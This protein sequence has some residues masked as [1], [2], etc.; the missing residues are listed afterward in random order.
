[1]VVNAPWCADDF[2]CWHLRH[3]DGILRS[4]LA[5]C[6]ARRLVFA[7]PPDFAICSALPGGSPLSPSKLGAP[8]DDSGPSASREAWEKFLR[9]HVLTPD[10]RFAGRFSSL[11]SSQALLEVGDGGV[12]ALSGPWPLQC[13]VRDFVIIGSELPRM[14]DGNKLSLPQVLLLSMPLARLGDLE[15]AIPPNLLTPFGELGHTVQDAVDFLT[16]LDSD[17]VEC[18]SGC[19][20]QFRQSH[21]GL[22]SAA[23]LSSG[24]TGGEGGVR[25]AGAAA[26][27]GSA[28]NDGSSRGGVEALVKSVKELVDHCVELASA[29]V[30]KRRTISRRRLQFSVALAVETLAHSLIYQR[31]FPTMCSAGQDDTNRLHLNVQRLRRRGVTREA[32][33]ADAV[34]EAVDLR[35]ARLV[36]EKL[37]VSTSPLEVLS[38]ILAFMDCVVSCI[39]LS[40]RGSLSADSLVPLLQHTIASSSMA[41]DTDCLLLGYLEYLTHFPTR[42]Q[43]R[44]DSEVEYKLVSF[45]V[46]VESLVM[47][48]GGCG[49][50]PSPPSVKA[51]TSQS[52]SRTP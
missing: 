2:A 3:A 34:L 7:L 15:T 37:R 22:R 45:R 33:G 16:H 30:A 5:D 52:G 21:R 32:L 14:D 35:P 4:I 44:L 10:R 27:A 12:A 24:G 28:G 17:V 13:G 42:L 41:L 8:R 49:G 23:F 48:G 43:Q 39:P 29:S 31:V 25:V 50:A 9:W 20:S 11:M 51:G 47:D 26:V 18:V 46:S 36:L 1:M 19:V 40:L 6:A 38:V